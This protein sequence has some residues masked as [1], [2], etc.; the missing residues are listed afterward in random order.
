MEYMHVMCCGV[1][2]VFFGLLAWRFEESCGEGMEGMEGGKGLGLYS[3]NAEYDFIITVYGP[4][5]GWRSI[6]DNDS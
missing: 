1:C 6:A 5:R 2:A 3:S 4:S